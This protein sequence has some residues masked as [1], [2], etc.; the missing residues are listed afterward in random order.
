MELAGASTQRA[1]GGDGVLQQQ[2]SG[3]DPARLGDVNSRCKAGDDCQ[4]RD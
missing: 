4:S 1:F 2:E 3:G